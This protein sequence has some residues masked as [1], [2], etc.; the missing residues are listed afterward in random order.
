ME[1]HLRHTSGSAT[2]EQTILP[3]QWPWYSNSHCFLAGAHGLELPNHTQALSKWQNAESYHQWQRRE[4]GTVGQLG[5]VQIHGCVI[6]NAGAGGRNMARS[7]AKSL[8]L[9]S[10]TD[11][12]IH[13]AS[14]R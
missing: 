2:Q 3:L 4:A 12:L 8:D 6:S 5:I 1:I 7:R 13:V 11:A 14:P 10:G 9:V